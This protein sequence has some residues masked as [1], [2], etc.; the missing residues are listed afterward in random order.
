M[1]ASIHLCPVVEHSLITSRRNPLV[2]RLRDLHRPSG[3]HEQGCVLLEGTHLLQ[4]ML[5]AGLA[6]ELVLATPDW[7]ERHGPLVA[8][9]PATTCLQ[10]I[11][12]A[13]V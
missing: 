4:E 5:R 7:L 13:H 8:S 9:L 6:A 1:P 3:R 10:E 11:G 2:G 12:R